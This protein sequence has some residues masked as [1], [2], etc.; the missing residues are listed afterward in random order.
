MTYPMPPAPTMPRIAHSEKLVSSRIPAQAT[1][2]LKAAGR[3]ALQ[4]MLSRLAPVT[5]SAS[6][7][8]SGMLSKL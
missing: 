6:I 2:W 8:S 1:I 3:I 7:V 4:K 5:S